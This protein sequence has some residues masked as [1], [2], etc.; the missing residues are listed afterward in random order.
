WG[1]CLPAGQPEL[2]VLRHENAVLHR[3][4]GRIRHEPADRLWFAA[5]AR[6]L[7]RRRWTEIFAVT[8]AT[9]LVWHRGLA[10][11]KYDTSK[12]PEPARPPT[13]PGIARLV[14][15]PARENP[16]WGYRRIHGELTKPGVPVAPSAV[17][18]IRHAAGIDPAP[19]RA[20]PAW[21]QFL[22]ARPPGSS[23]P[24]FLHADTVLLRRLH[25]L[26]FIAPGTRRMHLGGVTANPTGEWTVQQARNLA[27]T[28]GERFEDI[29][30]LIRDR[31]SNF[32]L[33]FDAVFQA[34]GAGILRTAV[35]V[36]RMNAICERHV[37]TLRRELLDRV[38][39]L[40]ERHLRSVLTEYQVHYNTARPHQ[41]IAQ[42]VPGDEPDAPRATVTGIDT[43]QIRRRPVLGGLINEYTHAA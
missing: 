32:T 14:V 2:L 20:G 16:R 27:L 23:R 35:Q 11:G 8:P 17:W 10:A 15:R 19:R 41:G 36:P 22:H 30:F 42:R 6:L 1:S 21:R 12:S 43:Q 39:I 29:R 37:G 3:H 13:V 40:G 25:V 28:V 33:S 5:L 24:A 18:E 9:L 34:T 31:G 38:L 26:V 4:A 7:P